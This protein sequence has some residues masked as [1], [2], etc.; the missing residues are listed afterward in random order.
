VE[1]AKHALFSPSSASRR[2]ACAGSLAMEHDLPD[3]STEYSNE[4]T[5]AHAVAKMCL[6]EGRPATAYVGRRVD[7]GPH[8]TYE[9][10][11]D[12]AEPVQRYVDFVNSLPGEKHFEVSVPIDHMTREEGAEGT[13]DVVAISD[14][15]EEII[16]ADLKFGAGV[17]VSAEKNMQG[18]MYAS[19]ALR[20]FDVMGTFK[21][22]KIYIFQPRIADEP[23]EWECSIEDLRAFEAECLACAEK[24]FG[25]LKLKNDGKKIDFFLSPGDEQCQFCK[26]RPTC[27]KLAA[28]VEAVVG[29]SFE[30]IPASGMTGAPSIISDAVQITCDDATL[31]LRH[32]AADLIEIWVKGVRAEM[33]RRLLAGH[34]MP[35]HKL[36]TGRQGNRAWTDVQAAE[37]LLRKQFRLPIEEAYSLKLISPTQAEKLLAKEHPKQWKKCE[38]LIARSP[39]VPSVAP[40]TD[41]RPALSIKSAADDFDEGADLV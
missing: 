1:A 39:G 23:S 36:V 5:C 13:A 29:Q 34:D 8:E 7:V 37:E 30:T 24:A 14:D 31:T 18:L 21:R 19:G 4:G 11:D 41:K 35:D 26:A 32:H 33:E 12:M 3:V 27:P 16:C 6:V 17:R 20:K 38:P 28:H 9:F 15:Y 10:R 40:K 25:V 22:V 2:A